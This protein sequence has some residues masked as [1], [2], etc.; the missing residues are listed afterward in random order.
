MQRSKVM[1]HASVIWVW[2]MLQSYGTWNKVMEHV[3]KLW[4]T[5]SST[6]SRA[7]NTMNWPRSSFS[8]QREL[9][10]HGIHTAAVWEADVLIRTDAERNYFRCMF[11]TS[12]P[13]SLPRWESV[14]ILFS[15][16]SLILQTVGW[17]PGPLEL[18]GAPLRHRGS[19]LCPIERILRRRFRQSEALLLI[20]SLAHRERFPSPGIDKGRVS[21]H[22]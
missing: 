6:G 13:E 4:G 12:S 11:L 2:N 14:F 15:M 7:A 21:N 9:T 8:I 5:C 18:E 10:M 20:H 1:E 22:L 17:H 19:R 16:R 3:V